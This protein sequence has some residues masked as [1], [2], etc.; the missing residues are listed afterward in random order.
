MPEDPPPQGHQGTL[1][2]KLS[3]SQADVV[4]DSWSPRLRLRHIATSIRIVE[5]SFSVL[6]PA[7]GA[8]AGR[9]F[10]IYEYADHIM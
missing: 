8:C 5:R 1:N 2:L 7:K 3:A 6:S 10:I 9:K 4:P